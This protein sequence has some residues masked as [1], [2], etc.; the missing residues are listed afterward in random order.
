MTEAIL[1]AT[2]TCE[3]C[4][5]YNDAGRKYCSQCSF[6]IE[7]T[8]DEKR[9]FRLTVSSRKRFLDDARS[10][11]KNA[12]IVI[13]VLAGLFFLVGLFMGFGADDFVAMIAN[14]FLCVIYLVLAVWCSQ[15][16]LGAILTAFII[17]LTLM[18]VNVLIDP[19]T[20][21]QGVIIKF[22]VI[23]GLVKGIRSAQEAKGY[24]KEL[25]NLKAVPVDSE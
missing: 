18:V 13:H 17:Y 21:F 23:A 9:S 24:L 10:K 25:Q 7:G 4:N 11:I 2:N 6:P 19:A 8:E 1:E 22:F 5:A 3:H 14:L 12:R 20:L 15:N 16:P